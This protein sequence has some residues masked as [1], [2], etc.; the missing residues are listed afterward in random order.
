VQERHGYIFIFN[1][2]QPLF[3]LPFFIGADPSNLVAGKTFEYVADCTWYMNAAHAFDTQHFAS[4][5][6]RKLLAP[7]SIDCPA[8]YARRNSYRAQV[9]GETSFDRMVRVFAGRIVETTLTIWGGNFAAVTADFGCVQSRFLMLMQPLEDARTLCQGIVFAPRGGGLSVIPK[10]FTLWARRKLTH[11]YL[12]DEARRLR[13]PRYNPASLGHNDRDMIDFFQWVAALP[14]GP[15]TSTQPKASEGEYE[16][17]PG[18]IDDDVTGGR[19][20]AVATSTN[21]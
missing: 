4:V 14:Q 17:M 6:D 10:R 8:P 2:A 16:N 9:V 19:A 12:A 7:P 1:G 3:P 15:L 5:H 11:A 18:C 21:G 20:G 13:G